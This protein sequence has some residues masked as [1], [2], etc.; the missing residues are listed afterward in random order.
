MRRSLTILLSLAA[1]TIAGTAHA[2]LGVVSIDNVSH[3]H[4]TNYLVAG[5]THQVDIRYDLTD[6]P[7]SMLLPG[8]NSFEV[9]SP[10]GADWVYLQGTPGPL[11]ATAASRGSSFMVYQKHFYFDGTSWAA[12][13]NDGLDPAPG[14]GGLDTKVGFLLGTMSLLGTAGYQSGTDN[15]IALTLEFTSRVADQG[16]HI[17]VDS[18]RALSMW[19]WADVDW[20][21]WDNGLGVSG[22]RCWEILDC[23]GDDTDGDGWVDNCDNCPDDYNPDQADRG[24]DG[25]GDACSDE[26][27]FEPGDGFINKSK[28]FAGRVQT[29]TMY[30]ANHA[31]ECTTN[32]HGVEAFAF[33]NS[34]KL[35]SPDG[36]N[37]NYLS[38]NVT[39]EFVSAQSHSTAGWE[40]HYYREGGTGLWQET[41]NNAHDPA[42]GNLTGTDTV[43]WMFANNGLDPN[44]PEGYEGS[45]ATLE[46][47]VNPEDVGLHI[48]IDTAVSSS[49]WEWSSG[50]EGS[51]PIWDH[52]APICFEITDQCCVG[53]VG[54]ANCS[55]DD[56]PTIGDISY[57]IDRKFIDT[58][59]PWWCC[60]EEADINQSGLPGDLSEGDITIGDISILIDYLF[61]TGP[62]LGL[63]NCF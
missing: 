63:N 1:L 8:T 59:E 22:P 45:A 25:I 6:L 18:S 31:L 48:C 21:L 12:T 60:L 47:S 29:V 26:V 42:P 44:T 39:S 43:G 52:S 11:V 7:S 27:W 2:Q 41:G 4:N 57:M 3:V 61:L 62:E 51:I 58:D 34:W 35:Y 32:W 28:L 5:N 49:Y 23:S 19:E 50:A 15:D 37:W 56:E 46:F 40:K 9:Y 13:G 24:G 53:R 33:A 38:G 30:F 10:D 54:D 55:G 14:S 17:C 16:L 36:A 20:P